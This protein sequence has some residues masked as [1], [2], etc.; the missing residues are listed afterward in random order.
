MNNNNNKKNQKKS[1]RNVGNPISYNVRSGTAKRGSKVEMGSDTFVDTVSGSVSFDANGYQVNPGLAD[2]NLA[3]SKEAAKYDQYEFEELSFKFIRSVAVTTTA[4]L[5]GLALDPNPNSADPSA[6]NRFNAY[7][8]RISDS[9]YAPVTLRIPRSALQ[10]WRFVRCGPLGSDLSLYDVGRL[11]IATQDESGTS[12][13][14]FVEMHYKVRF[15]HFHLE[16]ST[17]TPHNVSIFNLASSQTFNSG[18]IATLTTGEV[19]VDGLH[20]E[21]D[22]SSG[23]FTLPCGQYLVEVEIVAKDTSAENLQIEIDMQKDLTS[24]SPPV[25][26]FILQAVPA[27]GYIQAHSFCYLTSDGSNTYRTRVELT[28]AAGTLSCIADNCRVKFIALT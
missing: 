3:L 4:G 1:S 8:Y 9:V 28:G 5:I 22:Y 18:A 20:L 6:L 26:V 13:L 14:G 11:I 21:D 25:N 24:L 12:K 7:E 27:S 17:P 23:I 15:R 2:R 19:I 16:P 10:G